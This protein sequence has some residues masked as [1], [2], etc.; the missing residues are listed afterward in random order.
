MLMTISRSVP[1]W[2][3]PVLLVLSPV[4]VVWIVVWITLSSV[5][6]VVLL[7]IVWASWCPR[8]RY[9]LVVYSNSPM[10]QDYFERDVIP[11]ARDRAAV[12]NWSERKQW[13]YSLS[14][15]L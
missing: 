6:G 2:L 1:R 15:A 11:Q 12:L 9:A 3:R 5:F 13:R 7:L 10:W 8:G 4:I 14:V